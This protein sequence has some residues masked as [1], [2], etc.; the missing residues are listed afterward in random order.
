MCRPVVC[1]RT[2]LVCL[3]S[4]YFLQDRTFPQCIQIEQM[5]FQ[6]VSEPRNV[7]GESVN[8][9]NVLTFDHYL[10]AEAEL[11]TRPQDPTELAS[12]GT[13]KFHPRA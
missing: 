10:V 1:W 2:H 7:E 6:I 4:H 9:D 13:Q 5:A 12:R 11:R 3:K 8:A